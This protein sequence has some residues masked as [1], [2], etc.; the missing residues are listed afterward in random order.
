MHSIFDQRQWLAWLVK[1][2]VLVLT[3][4]LGIELAIAQLTPSSFPLRLFVTVILL[5]YAISVFYILLLAFWQ[6]YRVQSLLQVLTDL[7]LV[8]LV[9]YATGGIDSSFNFLYP[10]VIIVACILLPRTWAFLTAALAFILYGAVLELTYFEV[11]PSYSTTHPELK[12]LQAII[13]VNLFGY[14]A[15]AYLA[16]QLATKLR[17][18][19]VKLK[20]TS[21]ALEDLQALH[22]NIIQSIT[23]GLITTGLDGHITL[24]NTAAQKLLERAQE[25]LLSQ[26]VNRLF[27]DPLP[28]VESERA[29][30]EVR[31]VAPNGYRKTFRVQVSALAIPEKGT[32]GYV[33]TFDDLTEVRRLEREVRMQDRLAAVGRLAAAIAHEIRNPLTSIAGSVGLLSCIPDLSEEHR[34]LLQIVTRESERLNH[35]ITDFL[36]Y[37]RGKQYQFKKVDLLP[38]LEDTLTLLEHRL[39][40]QNNPIRVDRQYQLTEAWTLADGDKIKQ[41]FWNFCENAVRAM[42]DLGTLTVSVEPIGDDWQINFADTGPGMSPQLI[43]KIFEPFQSQ[44]EGG[45]GLGLAIV[46]QI[47]QAHEGKVWARS[48]VGQGSVFVLK[49][50]RLVE[51]ASSLPPEAASRAN[52]SAHLENATAAAVGGGARG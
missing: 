34:Q 27:L 51:A 50:R 14:L 13:L 43:E 31:I 45:T 40:A 46:Y 4:L 48:K 8:S 19:D 22:E 6:E 35:I 1:V 9:I 44:F 5:W 18:V 7:A 30:A 28:Q 11:V 47:V 38:L 33:Y 37:S 24:V 36:G 32:L 29:H 41:V 10:L 20:H 25:D 26:P 16:G 17:Q 39:A 12:S 15:V 49:L 42:R 3:C 23:G 21:G 52:H 2:R